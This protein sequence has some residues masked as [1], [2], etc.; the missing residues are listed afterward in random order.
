VSGA[1]DTAIR[2]V[3]DA[4]TAGQ[5]LRDFEMDDVA[6]G[7]IESHGFGEYFTHRTGHSIRRGC[8]RQRR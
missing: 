5:E 3:Q 4:V 7:Y 8:T 6:R 1:G 2:R